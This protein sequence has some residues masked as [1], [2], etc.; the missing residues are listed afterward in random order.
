MGGK[1]RTEGGTRK[2]RG[3]GREG[4]R[5]QDQPVK[6]EGGEA[7]RGMEIAGRGMEIAG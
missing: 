2:G 5:I 3:E 1:A 4:E 6:V 7:G